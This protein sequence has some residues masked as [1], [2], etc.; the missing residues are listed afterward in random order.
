M[1]RADDHT[2]ATEENLQLA[3]APKPPGRP[4]VRGRL[5]GGQATRQGHH[6]LPGRGVHRRVEDG[7]FHGKGIMTYPDGGVYTREWDVG[8]RYHDLPVTHGRHGRRETNKKQKK[9]SNQF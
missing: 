9:E 2:K 6:D 7:Y 4:Q 5:R 3:R 8:Q 1:F